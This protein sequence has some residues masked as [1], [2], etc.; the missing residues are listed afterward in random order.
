MRALTFSRY[1]ANTSQLFQNLNCKNLSTQRDIQ[2]A[3][4]VFRARG[5]VFKVRGPNHL[6]LSV[7]G[8]GGGG[9]GG[10]REAGCGVVNF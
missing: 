10:G 7:V 5:A 8:G 6:F 2:K 1:D 3:L 4:M 9:G